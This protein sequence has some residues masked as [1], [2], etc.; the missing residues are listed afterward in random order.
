[1]NLEEIVLAVKSLNRNNGAFYGFTTVTRPHLTK[2]NRT[3]KEPTNFTVEIRA[4]F[5]AMLGVNYENAVNN[6][7]EREGLERDFVAQKP[8][9]KHYVG[10]SRWLMESDNGGKFYI[11][12]DRIGG[13][14][15]EIFIDG[16]KATEEQ[17]EDL[18]V[19]YFDKPSVNPNGIT[20]R[21]YGI[22]SIKEIR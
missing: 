20:W 13:M 11:A 10:D 21:T 9:G 5:S 19:N 3:T 12:I 18:K 1:M 2:K 15:K 4:T 14:K 17:I 8:F 16:V 6:R 22:E 7:R